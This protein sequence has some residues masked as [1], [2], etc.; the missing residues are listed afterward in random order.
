MR[1]QSQDA[2]PSALSLVRRIFSP[3]EAAPQPSH[4]CDDQQA[5]ATLLHLCSQILINGAH[6]NALYDAWESEEAGVPADVSAELDAL[7]AKYRGLVVEVGKIK[8]RTKEGL[9][10]KARVTLTQ[11]TLNDDKTASPGD[12]NYLVFSLCVDAMWAGDRS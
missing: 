6:A 9:A 11:I 4:N 3:A 8:A 2:A 1:T 10:A 5:D 12:P 7:D